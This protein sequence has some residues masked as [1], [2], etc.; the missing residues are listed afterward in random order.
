[1]RKLSSKYQ[2]GVLFALGS[3]MTGIELPKNPF[4]N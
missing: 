2:N 4:I 1:M 3:E